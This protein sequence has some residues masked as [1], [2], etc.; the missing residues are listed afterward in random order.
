MKVT[1][2]SWIE[3]AL[4]DGDKIGED[5]TVKPCAGLVLHHVMSNGLEKEVHGV[6]LGAESYIGRKTWGSYSST[7]PRLFPKN[8]RVFSNSFFM[9]FMAKI[10]TLPPGILSRYEVKLPMMA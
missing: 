7:R 10:V 4:T 9:P 1:L 5:N 3:E 8:F 2:A 6:R